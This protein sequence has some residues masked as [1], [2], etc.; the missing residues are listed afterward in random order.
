MNDFSYS[1]DSWSPSRALIIFNPTAGRRQ[2]RRLEKTMA[3]LRSGGCIPTL[4]ETRESGDAERAA[5]SIAAGAF[6]VVIAAGGD[7]TVNEIANGL[8]KLDSPPPI[9]L[10]PLGTANVLAA[11]VGLA[12]TARAAAEAILSGK[13]RLIRLG[14]ANGRHFV[15]MASAGLDAQ[16]VEGLDLAFKRRM[17]R[18]AYVWDSLI[19]AVRYD[20]PSL[21]ILAD[22]R[23]FEARMAVVCK[24]RCYGGP[25]VAAP[26]ARLDAPLFYLVLMERGG[27]ANVLRY[28]IALALGRIG[29][30]ADVRVVPARH[31]VIS[32]TQGAP[33]QADGDV[34]A[35]LPVEI[36]LAPRTLELV[37]P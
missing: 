1:R 12:L 20:F 9:G 6:D 32:G 3:L 15:L 25:F 14:S 36:D 7:G 4:I 18:L 21:S 8:A 24:G 13:R 26:D 37:G 29:H 22:G 28:G 35:R 16:V 11:E 10:I 5:Q 31:V 30:L 17:G 23:K 33:V 19:R 2:R 27:L 34:A